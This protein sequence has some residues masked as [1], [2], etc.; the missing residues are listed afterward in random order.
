MNEAIQKMFGELPRVYEPINH[1]V[2]LGL[3]FSWRKRAAR[4]ASRGG[5]T[6]WLDVSTGTGEM[7]AY[8]RRLAGPGTT[9]IASDFSTPMLAKAREKR[10]AGSRRMTGRSNESESGRKEGARHGRPE[11]SRIDFVLADTGRLPFVSDC[12]DLVTI[13]LA[14]RNINTSR[15]SLISCLK[16]FHRVLRPG[17]RFIN[18]ETSQPS[19]PLVRRLFHQYVRRVLRPVGIA[20]SR[21]RGA[22]H[23]LASTICDFY[24][25][26]ELAE[27]MEEAGFKNV[28][29]DRFFLGVAALHRA[30]KAGE[31]EEAA[32]SFPRQEPWRQESSAQ[33]RS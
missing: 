14:T 8:L 28:T 4:L 20:F 12:L 17:G 7:A 24:D 32:W 13:S 33:K 3:D 10:E 30:E 27:I 6:L 29:F 18:L 31:L 21:S 5:G 15:K 19:S 16:E 26:H 9:V 25:A 11:V 23:Y 2:S 1:I 22:Y